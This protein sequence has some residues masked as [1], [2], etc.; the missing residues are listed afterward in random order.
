MTQD[1]ANPFTPHSEHINEIAAALSK[2]QGEF[3]P[4]HRDRDV[5]VA[6]RTGGTYSF[7]YATLG[8][9][10]E[11]V[12]PAL[13]KH[14]LSRSNAVT[15]IGNQ[16]F[17]ATRLIHESGQWLASYHPLLPSQPGA[18]AFGSAIT[19]ATRYNLSALLGIASED[20][21]DGNAADG[22]T[23]R[24]S[25]ATPR[26]ATTPQQ[27]SEVGD[28]LA[29]CKHA[30]GLNDFEQKFLADMNARHA[31]YGARI[32]ISDKQ[33]EVLKKIADKGGKAAPQH[34]SDGPPEW[35]NAP[36]DPIDDILPY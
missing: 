28:L 8:N 10:A 30:T 5:D 13:A 33:L 21:D 24:D 18:Q 6:T 22:N 26:P 7:K 3:Q 14:G 1:N 9:I 20:D 2:A 15:M 29:R 17:L 19:Y 34:A 12:K 27:A 32:K 25:G 16:P 11:A 23:V 35:H 4:I 31:E 36:N